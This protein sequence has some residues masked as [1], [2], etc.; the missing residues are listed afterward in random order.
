MGWSALRNLSIP[1]LA[2]GLGTGPAFGQSYYSKIW[3]S[4]LTNAEFAGLNKATTRLLAREPLSAGASESWTSHR[5][6]AHGTVRIQSTFRRQ[7]MLC[8]KIR[9]LIISAGQHGESTRHLSW[10]KTATGEWKI[11]S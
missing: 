3:G 7:G 11:L 5:S 6:G 2:V 4:S 9:Y 1:V 10:C 8:H